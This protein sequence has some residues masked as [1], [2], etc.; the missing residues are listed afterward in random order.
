MPFSPESYPRTT[1]S[2]QK[3]SFRFAD[4]TKTTHEDLKAR[5]L[6]L[7]EFVQNHSLLKEPVKRYKDLEFL[8]AGWEWSAFRDGN[9]V[10]KIPAGIFDEVNTPGYLENTKEAYTLLH[11]YFPTE[12]I[13]QTSFSRLDGFNSQTQEYIQGKDNYYVGYNT[14]NR[15]RLSHL[16]RFLERAIVMLDEEQ[17]LPDFDIR[18]ARGGF[19]VRN[20]I[21]ENETFLPKIIDFNAYYDAYRL[22]PE[23]TTE[24]VVLHGSHITDMLEW[25]QTRLDR[26]L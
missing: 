16:D 7:W 1:G 15:E 14:R 23:R 10:I 4:Y 25:V 22:Y 5:E 20:V 3:D 6:D 13:A 18:R 8:G 12:N 24:E 19:F 11:Q 26:D 17:W 2:I 21:I 9:K